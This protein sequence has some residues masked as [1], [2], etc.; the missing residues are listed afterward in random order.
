MMRAIWQRERHE[1]FAFCAFVAP[2]ALLFLVFTYWPILKSF[3]LSLTSSKLLGTRGEFVWFQ[4]YVQ[5][6]YDEAFWRVA[7]NT[8]VYAFLVVSVAQFFGFLVALL[9]NRPMAGRAI[10][11]TI[12]FTPQVTTPAAAALVWILLLDPKLGPLAYLYSAFG[13]DAR[14]WVGVSSMALFAVVVVGIWK[15]T[16]FAS[17][18]YLSGLQGL[19]LECIEAARLETN[20]R[21][22]MFRHIT[23]PLMTPVVF[24]LSVSGIIAAIKIFE[25]VL[26]MTRGGPVYPDSSTYVYHLYHV[27]F[28]QFRS[29][30]ASAIAIVFF[31]VMIVLTA[32]QFRLSRRWVHYGD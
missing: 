32:I 15:E 4:N 27:A 8:A 14:P 18:F 3:Y 28:E 26:I 1:W 25:V 12:C 7:F 31:F 30:E 13:I 10:F 19:P 23:F 17:I 21:F 2:N 6:I 29:G 22:R 20:S 24:F 5:L 9:L 16:A 11:R